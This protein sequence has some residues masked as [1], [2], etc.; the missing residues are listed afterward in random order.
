VAAAR[1]Y[2]GEQWWSGYYLCAV[3]S[4]AKP[5]CPA[6]ATPTLPP[7]TFCVVATGRD[8]KRRMCC[9]GG[10]ATGMQLPI[11]QNGGRAAP[12]AWRTRRTAVL[13]SFTAS[14]AQHCQPLL[15]IA[16]VT[17]APPFTFFPSGSLAALKRTAIRHARN[18]GVLTCLSA[19]VSTTWP[20][21]R[22]ACQRHRYFSVTTIS[23]PPCAA[24]F[25]CPPLSPADHIPLSFMRR[26]RDHCCKTVGDGVAGR[27][28]DKPANIY[29]YMIVP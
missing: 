8:S 9:A 23:P 25:L 5:A 27:K 10:A 26:V 24:P 22:G 13:F 3:G 20:G 15:S 11:A 4:L 18:A 14:R 2:L 16:A 29:L 19:L 28:E 21:G 7:Y 17:R 6:T 1:R 12:S